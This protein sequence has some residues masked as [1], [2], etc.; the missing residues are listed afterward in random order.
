MFIP[1]SDRYIEG[2]VNDA[3]SFVLRDLI[4]PLI[5]NKTGVHSDTNKITD[6]SSLLYMKKVTINK[7]T[8]VSICR[9][10]REKKSFFFQ[11]KYFDNIKNIIDKLE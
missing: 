4:V 6:L 9:T 11:K 8:A 5:N 10:R 3:I 7:S 2:K 1:F